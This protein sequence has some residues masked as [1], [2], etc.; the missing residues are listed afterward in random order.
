GDVAAFGGERFGV[1]LHAALVLLA[2]VGVCVGFVASVMYLV[3]VR[4]LKAKVPPGRGVRL[5]SLERLEEMN[6]RAVVLAFPLLTAGLLVGLA[7]MLQ[8]GEALTDLGH[9]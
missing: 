8:S 1:V 5:L 2:A 6:R 3:Q 4:R 7:L 9:P